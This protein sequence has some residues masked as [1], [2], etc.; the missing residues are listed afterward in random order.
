[1]SAPGDSLLTRR[2]VHSLG[3]IFA[4][5]WNALV[6]G[7][8]PFTTHQFLHAL[9]TTGCLTDDAGWSAHHLILEDA[10]GQLCAAAPLYSKSNS[11]GEF[12]FDFSWAQA[13][14]QFGHRYYPK[15]VC[16]VPFMPVT[17]PRL[18]ARDDTSR[19]ELARQLLQLPQASGTSSVHLL[20]GTTSDLQCLHAAGALLRRDCQY[21]W[22]NRHYA[23]FDDFLARLTSKRRKEIRR[24]RRKVAAANIHIDIL[25]PAQTGEALLDTLYAFYA[26]TYMVRGQMPYLT[27]EFFWAIGQLL[28]DQVLYFVAMHND[29]PVGMAFML[30]DEHTLYGRHWGCLA[31]Y[32][33]L[34]FETCYYAGIT[35]CI[36]NGLQRF[37]AGVQGAH[38]LRRG[39]EPVATHSAHF[40]PHAQFNAAVADFLTRETAAVAQFHARQRATCAFPDGGDGTA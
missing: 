36:D 15:L 20:F 38:K 27:R 21:Q 12:V 3:D 17:G 10:S 14:H 7:D 24:E 34:H 28:P 35:Y 33:S 6:G 2:I 40:F 32:D 22:H 31:D 9:E 29:D 8:Y 16:G 37:D 18:L 11:F 23:T 5:Q 19:N 26:R 4:P 30:R 13:Y 1:M 25:T 39:F